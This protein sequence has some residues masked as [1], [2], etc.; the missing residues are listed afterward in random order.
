MSKLKNEKQVNTYFT[1]KFNPYDSSENL[2]G[3]SLFVTYVH[4]ICR[5]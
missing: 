3:M 4:S 2:L 1:C 5:S